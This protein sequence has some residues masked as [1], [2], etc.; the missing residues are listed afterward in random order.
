MCGEGVLLEL[1]AHDIREDLEL[2][3]SMSTKTGT[4]FNTV[5]VDDAK[6]AEL[7]MR[8][9]LIPGKEILD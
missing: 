9:V 6:S 8:W 4:W 7:H 5:L 3:M 2:A 1:T